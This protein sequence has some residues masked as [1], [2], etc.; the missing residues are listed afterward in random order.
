MTVKNVGFASVLLRYWRGF[1]GGLV[2]VPRSV[3]C[4][5]PKMFLNCIHCKLPIR[6]SIDN[7]NAEDAPAVLDK[8]LLPKLSVGGGRVGIRKNCNKEPRKWAFFS[9]SGPVSYY[10]GAHI[11]V[12]KEIQTNIC[13]AAPKSTKYRLRSKSCNVYCWPRSPIVCC[14]ARSARHCPALAR[15]WGGD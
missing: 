9:L 8:C 10:S 15:R 12:A 1:A 6:N 3:Q 11:P 5:V 2:A 14:P 7:L 13:H 4:D